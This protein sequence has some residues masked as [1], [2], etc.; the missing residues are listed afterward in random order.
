VKPKKNIIKLLGVSTVSVLLGY[1]FLGDPDVQFRSSDANWSDSEIQMKGRDF[2]SIVFFF[3]TYKLKCG[4]PS[5]TLIRTTQFNW[6]NVFAWPSYFTARKW[7]VTYGPPDPRIGDHFP[8]V[9]QEHCNN[10]SL[11]PSVLET[12]ESNSNRFMD[13]L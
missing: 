9:F 11:S 4:A 7:K 10:E 6:Y 12:V 5:A 8:D 13:Q 1:L 2:A 3:E